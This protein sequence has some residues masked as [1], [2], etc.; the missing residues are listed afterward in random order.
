MT[1]IG[2]T[3][4]KKKLS[5]SLWLFAKLRPEKKRGGRAGFKTPQG[6]GEKGNP[7][8]V[9]R[10]RGEGVSFLRCSSVRERKEG[11]NEDLVEILRRRFKNCDLES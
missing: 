2:R 7:Q 4:G 6:Q 8:I 11:C 3:A 9:I 1:K 10:E 5:H